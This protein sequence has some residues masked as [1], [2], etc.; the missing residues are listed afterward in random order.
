MIV[1]RGSNLSFR[2]LNFD[3]V[4]RFNSSDAC[5]ILSIYNDIV[6]SD[7]HE[8][9]DHVPTKVFTPSSLRC[10]RRAWFRLR[11]VTPECVI[12]TD[13]SLKFIADMGTSCHRI[14]QERFIHGLSNNGSLEWVDVKDYLENVYHPTCSYR[15]I[16][17]QYEVKVEFDD[18]PVRFSVDGLLKLQSDY[19]LLEIKSC[20]HSK[21]SDLSDPRKED[22]SQFT[23]YCT[24]LGLDRGFFLYID[25][26][27]GDIKCYEVKVSDDDKRKMLDM[28]K[29]VQE[30]V[31]SGIAPPPLPK[32]DKWCTP[33]YCP[34][35]KRCSEYGR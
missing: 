9:Y 21:W 32:G 24:L 5:S 7:I 15:T 17:N 20:E 26:Q 3:S 34:Y 29:R 31:Q 10:E 19:C 22:I 2:T 33:A 16:R 13:R 4:C 12:D 11:G 30:S 1:E 35:Y 23:A 6:D 28:F 14:I 25:R 8:G 27:Y 18:P